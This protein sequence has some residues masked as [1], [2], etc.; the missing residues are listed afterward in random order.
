MPTS[1]PTSTLITSITVLSLIRSPAALDSRTPTT[2]RSPATLAPVGLTAPMMPLWTTPPTLASN[3][4]N[5]SSVST[6]AETPTPPVANTL[7]PA[8]TVGPTTTPL[9][10]ATKP[11]APTTTP[12]SATVSPLST[13]M[14]PV[15]TLANPPAPAATSTPVG[16]A[17]A[18][19]PASPPFSVPDTPNVNESPS[20]TPAAITDPLDPPV[21]KSKSTP[22]MS[23]PP[24]TPV[25]P[26]APAVTPTPTPNS[27]GFCKGST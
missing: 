5:W 2:S 17:A 10:E 3:A 21:S 26:S 13:V 16:F 7:F 9:W 11:P 23:S 27:R 6:V 25:C 14:P 1:K 12:P 24:S 20:P 8:L 19:K 15:P 22:P 18:W 4:W